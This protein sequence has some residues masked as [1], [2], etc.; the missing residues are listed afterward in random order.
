MAEQLEP[1]IREE[2]TPLREGVTTS[3]EEGTLTGGQVDEAIRTLGPLWETLLL[4]GP[5]GAEAREQLAWIPDML[6]D[7]AERAK[8]FERLDEI[9]AEIAELASQIEEAKG[10]LAAYETELNSLNVALGL[11][12]DGTEDLRDAAT[13][14]VDAS[15]AVVAAQARIADL[16]IQVQVDDLERTIEELAGAAQRLA[17]A[18]QAVA[19]AQERIKG[20][21]T[22]IPIDDLERTIE[23]LRG[24]PKSGSQ[25]REQ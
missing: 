13:K 23:N 11:A 21:E 15:N 17:D 12:T 25:L 4:L 5:A 1:L 20:L 7:L 3:I 2:I 19:Q 9:V 22:Q 18:E 10:R 8:K 24:L 6:E 16:E 14:L